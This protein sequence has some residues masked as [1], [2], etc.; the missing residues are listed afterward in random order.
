[1][2]FRLTINILLIY[3]EQVI[4]YCCA[5][6]VILIRHN[7]SK[8][9]IARHDY[10]PIE[11]TKLAARG[12][13]SMREIARLRLSGSGN[14]RRWRRRNLM[15]VVPLCR[16]CIEARN[17]YGGRPTQSAGH[18]PWSMVHDRM[19]R[20]ALKCKL[21]SHR[22]SPSMSMGQPGLPRGLL[23]RRYCTVCTRSV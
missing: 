8:G 17:D 4:F 14:E 2:Y 18:G 12:V 23:K 19:P 6:F 22:A 7:S 13:S 21:V 10:L 3:N 15:L 11:A 1:M 16:R 5:Q 9:L 20:Y